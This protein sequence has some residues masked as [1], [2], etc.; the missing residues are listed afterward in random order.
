GRS[1]RPGHRRVRRAEGGRPRD[2]G[3][4]RRR[5]AVQRVRAAV[6]G[7]VRAPA[8]RAD[9]RRRHRPQGRA[10]GGRTTVIRLAYPLLL[11]AV[12]FSA[13]VYGVLARRNAILVLM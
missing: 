1:G 3:G 4:R 12:L 6:R 2:P 10:G 13:G 8:G 7:G 11:S 5:V 9:R